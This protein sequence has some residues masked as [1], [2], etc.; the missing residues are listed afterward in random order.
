MTCA[1]YG[2]SLNATVPCR[3]SNCCFSASIWRVIVMIVSSRVLIFSCISI[4]RPSDGERLTSVVESGSSTAG[5]SRSR[6]WSHGCIPCRSGK[7]LSIQVGRLAKRR[8]LESFCL[9]GKCFSC[10]HERSVAL[11]FHAPLC[12]C[13]EDE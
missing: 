1:V 4:K 10:I 9:V 11:A 6:V 2:F 13:V 3:T 12:V 8:T 5:C 7:V